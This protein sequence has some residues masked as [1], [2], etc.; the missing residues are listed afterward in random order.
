M[1]IINLTPHEVI[2]C[3]K[4]IPATT[5]PARVEEKIY[6]VAEIDYENIQIPIIEKSFGGIQNLPPQKEGTVY[7][8]SLLVAQA[9]NREDVFAIGESIRDGKGNIVGAKSLGVV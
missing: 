9:A 8:V 6:T 1:K 3:G 5:P 7:I 4:K 2:I